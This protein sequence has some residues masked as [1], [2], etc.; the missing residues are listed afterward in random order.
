MPAKR[1]TA[2]ARPHRITEEAIAAFS[3][4]DRLGVHRALNLPPW[5][6]SPLDV[7]EDEESPWPA[8]SGGSLSW[9]FAV[10]LRREL[11]AA[12]AKMPTRAWQD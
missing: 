12:G 8:A 9:P 11:L 5:V 10:E 7:S 4:G 6:P 1:R 2:K 3:S